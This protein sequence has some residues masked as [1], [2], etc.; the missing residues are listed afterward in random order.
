MNPVDQALNR[1]CQHSLAFGL[2]ADHLSGM[3]CSE[4]AL[5]SA[6]SEDWVRERIES[7][8]MCLERQIR[9]EVPDFDEVPSLLAVGPIPA[10]A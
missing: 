1:L 5:L 8:R 4:L 6:K 2:Y 3:S 10:S 9:I 7:L